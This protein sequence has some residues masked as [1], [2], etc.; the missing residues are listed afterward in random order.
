MVVTLS[1]YHRILL[2]RLF[3]GEA[4]I[5]GPEPAWFAETL[6]WVKLPKRQPPRRIAESTMRQLRGEESSCL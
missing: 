3:S 1:I 4:L 5:G 6:Q 2:R